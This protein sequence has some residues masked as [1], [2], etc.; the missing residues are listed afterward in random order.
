MFLKQQNL[1]VGLS[2]KIKLNLQVASAVIRSKGVVLLLFVVIPAFFFRKKGYINF[3]NKV[4]PSSVCPSVRL[5]VRVSVTFLVNISPPKLLD[6]AT[7]NFV[8]E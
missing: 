7:S 6:V 5:C 4:S 1:G 3:C 2:D 8:A